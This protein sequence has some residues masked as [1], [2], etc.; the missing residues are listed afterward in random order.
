MSLLGFSGR[1]TAWQADKYSTQFGDWGDKV[2]I[3]VN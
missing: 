2:T 1:N 3:E